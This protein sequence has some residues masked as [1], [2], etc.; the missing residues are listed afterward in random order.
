MTNGNH[1]TYEV[2]PSSTNL[3]LVRQFLV[4][5]GVTGDLD[6]HLDRILKVTVPVDKE[7]TFQDFLNQRTV[8]Y[9][10]VL[11][12]R[13]FGYNDPLFDMGLK[14]LYKPRM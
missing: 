8:Q 13:R 2:F 9:T 3:A 1:K 5:E 4:R 14:A 12:R 10:V 6:F 7:Q 11:T